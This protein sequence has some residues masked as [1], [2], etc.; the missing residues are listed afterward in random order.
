MRYRSNLHLVENSVE[1]STDFEIDF[2]RGP[3][4]VEYLT[5][6]Y[7]GLPVLCEKQLWDFAFAGS[8][9]S[10]KYAPLHHNFTLPFDEQI[11]LWSNHTSKFVPMDKNKALVATF[12]GINDVQDTSKY[13][14]N[15]TGPGFSRLYNKMIQTQF[16]GNASSYGLKNTTDFYPAYNQADVG[17]NYE[18]YGCQPLEPIEEYFWFILESNRPMASIYKVL[19]MVETPAVKIASCLAPHWSSDPA[20]QRKWTTLKD[21]L[22][23]LLGHSALMR[24]PEFGIVL[25]PDMEVMLSGTA[26]AGGG[27]VHYDR[28]TDSFVVEHCNSLLAA[29]G[30]GPLITDTVEAEEANDLLE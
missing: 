7:E 19:V 29:S 12:I 30:L 16:D 20:Q 14:L 15:K 17:W 27:F 22:S 28:I 4:W 13:P 25:G 9:I 3:N 1:I 8:D 11:E 5:Q 2:S 21:L 26:V 24:L 10:L 18:K 6:C 23:L